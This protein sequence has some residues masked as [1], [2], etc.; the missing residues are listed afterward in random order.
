MDMSGWHFNLAR[1]MNSWEKNVI[2]EF[3]MVPLMSHTILLHIILSVFQRKKLIVIPM[4]SALSLVL[5]SSTYKT[6]NN[7]TEESW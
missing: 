1:E 6:F 4:T 5:L 2:I 7:I 3:E